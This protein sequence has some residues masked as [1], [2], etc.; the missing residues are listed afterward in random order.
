AP[1]VVGQAAVGPGPAG[2]RW[3]GHDDLPRPTG[4]PPRLAVLGVGGGR[5]DLRVRR[6]DL[7]ESRGRRDD[8]VL[9]RAGR[10]NPHRPGW[11]LAGLAPLLTAPV[12]ASRLFDRSPFAGN[13]Y[14][15]LDAQPVHL[16][17]SY[18]TGDG[19]ISDALQ[20]FGYVVISSN[21]PALFT[22]VVDPSSRT[23]TDP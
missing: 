5:A 3:V 8:G 14:T 23:E 19:I 13:R 2:R 11:R 22:N 9:R 12:A 10:R 7:P 21:V 15:P 4:A 6:V 17:A 16:M 18:T 1:G 20:G